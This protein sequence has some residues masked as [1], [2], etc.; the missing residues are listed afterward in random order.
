[1]ARVAGLFVGY[2]S[3]S[4]RSRDRT[5]GTSAA[6]GVGA[7]SRH[8]VRVE[9]PL[10]EDYCHLAVTVGNFSFFVLSLFSLSK[11]LYLPRLV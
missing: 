7:V 5:S 6:M 8:F 10:R 1:M 4:G 11:Y 2:V 9:T 3:G